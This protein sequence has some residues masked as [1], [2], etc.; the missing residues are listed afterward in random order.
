MG[1]EALPARLGR[2]RPD[3]V[4][5][6]SYAETVLSGER[7]FFVSSSFL[8]SVQ[9][10]P[11]R[12]EMTFRF[13]SGFEI[14]FGDFTR[15]FVNAFLAAPSKGEWYHQVVKAG[16]NGD[17]TWQYRFPVISQT[18]GQKSSRRRDSVRKF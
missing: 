10:K 12:N 6:E 18:R 14:T 3:E 13:P 17:G 1:Q 15:D 9:W 11:L 4:L 2:L 7:S 5:P 8:E 16:Y